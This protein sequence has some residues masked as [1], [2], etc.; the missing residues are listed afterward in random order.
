MAVML[1]CTEAVLDG[2]VVVLAD[3]KAC[4]LLVKPAGLE[5][6]IAEVERT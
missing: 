6:G 4:W 3:G 5:S 1:S 2:R